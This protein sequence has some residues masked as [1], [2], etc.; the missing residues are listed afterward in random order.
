MD[1]ALEPSLLWLLWLFLGDAHTVYVKN[2]FLEVEEENDERYNL[3]RS[4]SARAQESFDFTAS[5]G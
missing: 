5:K 4:N 3:K 1:Q 2:T